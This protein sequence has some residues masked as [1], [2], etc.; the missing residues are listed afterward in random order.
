MFVESRVTSLPSLVSRQT[1]LSLLF[2]LELFLESIELHRF[3][4]LKDFH[5]RIHAHERTNK[6]TQIY[7]NVK[8]N[9]KYWHVLTIIFLSSIFFLFC[10]QVSNDVHLSNKYVAKEFELLS[11][12]ISKMRGSIQKEFSWNK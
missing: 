6:H 11:S 3:S 10:C 8:M 7:V 4:E 12:S 5:T 1:F 2:S 9:K